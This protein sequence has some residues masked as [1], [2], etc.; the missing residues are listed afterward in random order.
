MNVIE[1]FLGAGAFLL[2][3][4]FLLYSVR[5]LVYARSDRSVIDE[6]LRRYTKATDV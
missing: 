6:R 2:L 5:V 3:L 4:F 1:V